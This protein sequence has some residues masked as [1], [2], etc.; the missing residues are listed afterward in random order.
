MEIEKRLNEK[1][2]VKLKNMKEQ[3]KL[4]GEEKGCRIARKKVAW[5]LQGIQ[6]KQVFR[7]AFNEITDQKEQL[8]ALEG[9][10]NLKM[11]DK[12]KNVRKKT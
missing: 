4:Y 10:Y 12:E 9:K 6:T 5:N 1:C 3:D 11:K 2:K 7:Q 8:I